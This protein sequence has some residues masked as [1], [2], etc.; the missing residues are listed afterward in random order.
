ME[1]TAERTE[2]CIANLSKENRKCKW[3]R[4][5]DIKRFFSV[6]FCDDYN[7][8]LQN[9]THTFSFSFILCATSTSFG[10][11]NAFV[12]VVNP[13][14]FLLH[15]MCFVRSIGK[16]AQPKNIYCND[17][18]WF[19]LKAIQQWQKRSDKDKITNTEK[20]IYNMTLNDKWTKIYRNM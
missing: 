9:Y 5:I 20:N 7:S 2:V 18:H 10:K 19:L 13:K 1:N 3:N 6:F 14:S 8:F 4:E 15:F 12:S 16:A 11:C 17:I